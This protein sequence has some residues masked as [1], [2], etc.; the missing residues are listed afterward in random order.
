M[1][2]REREAKEA[3]QRQT[4]ALLDRAYDRV[5]SSQLSK[6]SA[7]K[8]YTQ[9]DEEAYKARIAADR[10]KATNKKRKALSAEHEEL[11]RTTGLS[12]HVV[13][14]MAGDDDDDDDDHDDDGRARDS[15]RK[16]KKKKKSSSSSAKKLVE[17]NQLLSHTRTCYRVRRGLRHMHRSLEIYSYTE[18]ME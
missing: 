2:P 16:R 12:G 3:K 18:N 1:D 9:D 17:A 13:A 6:L 5:V 7:Q 10:E 4:Q 14:L 11:A 15:S 8:T